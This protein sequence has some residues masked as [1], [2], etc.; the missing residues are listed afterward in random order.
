MKISTPVI[1]TAFFLLALPLAGQNGW[2]DDA[3]TCKD[4]SGDEAIAACNRALQ[5]GQLSQSNM[6][7]TYVNRGVE[8]RKK[9]LVDSALTDYNEAL[10]ITPNYAI[11]LND[12]GNAWMDKADYDRALADFN[13]AIRFDPNY[14]KAYGNR[15]AAL[16]CKQQY[17]RAVDDFRQSIRLKPSDKYAPLLLVVA[18]MHKGNTD[19]GGELGTNIAAFDQNWPMPIAQLYQG[20]ITPADLETAANAANADNDRKCDLTFYLGEWQLFHGQRAQ[21]IANLKAALQSCSTTY[22]EHFITLHD[23][24]EWQ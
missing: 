18:Q 7:V 14:V 20:K 17:D 23:L 21:G 11:A 6:A 16:I 13:D 9:G 8:L 2:N 1:A 10:R 12:R 19:Y 4:K 15:A 5:S 22:I 3:Q 24:N